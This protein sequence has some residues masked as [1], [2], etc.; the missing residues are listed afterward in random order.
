MGRLSRF[1]VPAATYSREFHIAFPAT[2]VYRRLPLL[3]YLLAGGT[4]LNPAPRLGAPGPGFSDLMRPHA[5]I[6]FFYPRRARTAAANS[7]SNS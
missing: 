3:R 4:H 2:T 6:V 5:T 1:R 7:L